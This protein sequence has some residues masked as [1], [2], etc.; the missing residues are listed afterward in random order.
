MRKYT[1]NLVDHVFYKPIII[2][3]KNQDDAIEKVDDMGR[4]NL[5]INYTEAYYDIR[6]KGKKRR[7]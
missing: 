3:A 5:P 4:L 1:V 7:V 6:R 2:M